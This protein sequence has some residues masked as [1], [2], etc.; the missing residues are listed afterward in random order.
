MWD[1]RTAAWDRSANE[2]A[3]S[4][5]RKMLRARHASG[6]RRVKLLAAR[7]LR[8]SA[9]SPND[10]ASIRKPGAILYL[11]QPREIIKYYIII[12]PISNAIVPRTSKWPQLNQETIFRI[13]IGTFL[14]RNRKWFPS[15]K[16]IPNKVRT[17]CFPAP[18]WQRRNRTRAIRRKMDG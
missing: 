10:L 18:S 2:N 6:L 1:Y 5:R 16:E 13:Y 11:L 7:T 12:A 15:R 8:V 9:K 17:H 4:F 14:R 3:T